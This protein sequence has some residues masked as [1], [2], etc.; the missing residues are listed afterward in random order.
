MRLVGNKKDL[1]IDPS[2]WDGQSTKGCL[3]FGF[4]AA[5]AIFTFG[6][7][8]RSCG[9]VPAFSARSGATNLNIGDESIP[10][11]IVLAFRPKTSTASYPA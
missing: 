4:W 8:L 7:S 11:L 9:L 2:L 1:P 10:T 5:H 6:Q 3:G